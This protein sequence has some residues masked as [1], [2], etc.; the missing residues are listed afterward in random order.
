MPSFKDTFGPAGWK[1]FTD[2]GGV[3]VPG[4]FCKELRNAKQGSSFLLLR[5]EPGARY[6]GPQQKAFQLTLI[7][8]ALDY[9]S[10]G[11]TGKHTQRFSKGA[12]VDCGRDAKHEFTSAGVTTALVTYER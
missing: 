10:Q 1:P 4:L 3:S 12:Y 6:A 7:E 8:G 11:K 9:A 5:F 2:S